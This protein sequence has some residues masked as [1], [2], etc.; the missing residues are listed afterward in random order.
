MLFTNSVQEEGQGHHWVRGVGM[1]APSSVWSLESELE[2]RSARPQKIFS[3]FKE[4]EMA[5]RRTIELPNVGHTY[6][7]TTLGGQGGQ[8]I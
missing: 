6:N 3:L 8:I 2:G 5:L 4:E 1:H 7:P